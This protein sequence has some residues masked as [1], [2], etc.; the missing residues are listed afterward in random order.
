[1]LLPALWR[2]MEQRYK[3]TNQAYCSV[4]TPSGQALSAENDS[5][6]VASAYPSQIGGIVTRRRCESVEFLFVESNTDPALWELPRG[7]AGE[8]EHPAETAVRKV[9]EAAGIGAGICRD[10]D[11][12]LCQL[13]GRHSGERYYVMQLKGRGL[14]SDK[15]RRHEWLP[16][17]AAAERVKS[18]GASDLLNSAAALE[19]EISKKK[20]VAPCSLDVKGSYSCNTLMPSWSLQARLVLSQQ[21]PERLNPELPCGW[22]TGNCL[23]IRL[24]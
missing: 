11:N 23:L 13:P 18:T 17:H 4:V 8:N 19:A 1:M 9:H 3:A 24:S 14:P 21:L 2:F 12:R 5:A 20:N 16:Q 7:S 10:E 6:G 22:T 15:G